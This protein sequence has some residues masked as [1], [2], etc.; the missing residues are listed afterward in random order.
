MTT[1]IRYI[2]INALDFIIIIGRNDF[3]QNDFF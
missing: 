1:V 2:A 3:V